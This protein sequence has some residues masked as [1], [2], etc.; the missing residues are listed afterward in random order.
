[1]IAATNA[2]TVL[3]FS[4]GGMGPNTSD[5]PSMVLLPELVFRW[6]LGERLLEVPAAW[7]AAPDQVPDP[8]GERSSW[9]RAW[10]PNLGEQPTG[11]QLRRFVDVLPR[12]ARQWIRG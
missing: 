8:G 2:E 6:A 11:H 12:P 10:Y 7:S 3:V 1:V 5:A 9:N 4:M